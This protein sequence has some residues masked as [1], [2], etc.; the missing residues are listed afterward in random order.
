MILVI[1]AIQ[2]AILNLVQY[3]QTIGLEHKVELAYIFKI[4]EEVC[5]LLTPKVAHMEMFQHMEAV[6]TVGEDMQSAR[7]WC[8]CPI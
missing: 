6:E 8:G 7:A 4:M 5:V 2:M 3:M 1:I